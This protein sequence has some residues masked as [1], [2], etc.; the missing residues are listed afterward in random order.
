MGSRHAVQDCRRSALRIR[1]AVRC[2][3][4]ARMREGAWWRFGRSIRWHLRWRGGRCAAVALC[5]AAALMAAGGTVQAADYGAAL[6][7]AQSEFWRA[8]E[9]GIEQAA[10][11]R[12][13]KVTVRSPMDD[14]PHTRSDNLQLK[15][16][17][18]M[19]DA[20]VKSIILAPIPVSGVATPVQLPVPLVFVDRPG[21]DYRALSTISTDNYQAG[22]AAAHTLQGVLPHGARIAVL[23]LAP[24]VVSTSARESGFVD[25]AKE[26][27]FEIAVDAYI[28][29]GIH[30]PELAAVDAINAYRE[31]APGR[32]L[33]A[34]FT[35]TD[36]TTLAAVRAVDT[37]ALKSRPKLVGFDYRPAFRQYLQSGVL[38]AVIAQDAYNMGY[39]AMMTLL[40]AEAGEPIPPEIR[41]DVLVLT[42]ANIDNPEIAKKLQQYQR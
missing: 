31:R 21:K 36:F 5:I 27:G 22:R 19:I 41:I 16:V 37:L 40:K 6:A 15:L 42:A 32:E 11:E 25:A 13:A 10:S 7:G 39:V 35:P 8:M 3:G 23:R 30:E 33:D 4:G 2:C 9:A 38:H 20:G 34:I 26:Q 12:G 24:D 17:Q 18:R 14:D 29:H 28:G 1:L